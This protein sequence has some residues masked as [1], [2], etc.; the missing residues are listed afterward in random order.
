MKR[1]RLLN[2]RIIALL[3][4]VLII[5]GGVT[6]GGALFIANR[7]LPRVESL[8]EYRP[9]LVSRIYSDDNKIVGE[10]YIEK[11]GLVP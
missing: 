9:S 3:I 8:R 7:N 10:Y 5:A 4:V 11:R 2:F 6:A 1:N